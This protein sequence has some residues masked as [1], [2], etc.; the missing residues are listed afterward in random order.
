MT[1]ASSD[2]SKSAERFRSRLSELGHE[3][4]VLS[5]AESTRTAKEA[6]DTIGCTVAQIA[7]SIVFRDARTDEP[8][9]VVASGTNRVS[10]AKVRALADT[11]LEQA[12][13][14]YVKK[15]LG[16]AI[17]GVPPAGHDSPPRIFLDEDL[18]RFDEVWA[19]AGTPFAVFRLS[20][21]SLPAL[22]GATWCDVAE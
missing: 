17:G 7:K 20:P 5:L 3:V 9:L 13:G 16:F 14:S 22:T 1:A 12:S 4:E 6:A 21:E 19:A 8:I 18:R 11:E 2:L 10:P 15:R